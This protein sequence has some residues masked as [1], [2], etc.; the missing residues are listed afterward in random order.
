V[1]PSSGL[2]ILLILD[3]A[4][5]YQRL[6]RRGNRVFRELGEGLAERIAAARSPP[7]T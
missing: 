5:A 4:R 3:I 6:A 1:P 2:P 7:V